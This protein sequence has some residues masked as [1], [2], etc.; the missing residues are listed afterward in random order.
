MPELYAELPD[1][2]P[3]S[4]V[5]E[6]GQRQC[7]FPYYLSLLAQVY[8]KAGY[9]KERLACIDEA[10]AEA[11]SHNERWWD[12]EVHRLLGC[13]SRNYSLSVCAWGLE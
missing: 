5:T 3:Y 7:F 10:L 13:S 1:L 9:P 8:G 12:A 11:R 2:P 4:P 6:Y